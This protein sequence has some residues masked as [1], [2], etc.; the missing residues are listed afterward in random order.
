[1]WPPGAHNSALWGEL[2]TATSRTKGAVGA[3]LD[4]CTRDTPQVLEQNFP[5][6]CTGLL[7]AG[8][9]RAHLRLR[10]PL[11]HRDRPGHHP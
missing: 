2:L 5:V 7:G 4:G 10:L 3:V 11:H 9:L 8:F 1:M 6:F